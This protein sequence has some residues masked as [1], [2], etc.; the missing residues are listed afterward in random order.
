MNPPFLPDL[1]SN[2]PQ[3]P[4]LMNLQ[5]L[6][7][8]VALVPWISGV[9]FAGDSAE[10]S[11]LKGKIKFAQDK[12][13][14]ANQKIES[15]KAD[16][17]RIAKESADAQDLID[18]INSLI[19]AQREN[20]EKIDEREAEFEK[21]AVL[22]SGYR[23]HFRSK[24]NFKVGEEL[25]SVT[26]EEGRK[27]EGVVIKEITDTTLKVSHSGGFGQIE[28]DNLPVS[29]QNRV[30]AP[31]S[32]EAIAIDPDSIL[33]KRPLALMSDDQ[34]RLRSEQ[35]FSDRRVADQK[36]MEEQR[37]ARD[38]EYAARAEERKA[39]MAAEDAKRL[40]AQNE[41]RAKLERRDEIR[42]KIDALRR[43]IYKYN[44]AITT[45]TNAKNYRISQL[46]SGSIRPSAAKLRDVGKPYD[47]KIAQIKA[48][49]SEKEKEIETLDAE[50]RTVR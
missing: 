47:D 7:V 18:G 45:Q 27:L 43:E 1:L 46:T 10:M 38:A 48:L 26:L 33:E 4:I 24:V 40:Q 6:I 41:R 19:V 17:E 32:T 34:K 13:D 20:E 37:A 39:Q 2:N 25:G 3:Y 42:S 23:D 22:V 30:V 15:R 8:C 44:D 29:L 9:S 28:L 21:I 11:R 31:P 35:K 16:L 5:K 50:Y 12:L 36:R 14:A 49:I